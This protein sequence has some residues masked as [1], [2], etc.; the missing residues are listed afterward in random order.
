M[1][2]SSAVP[3]R[4][5]RP[6]LT[7][8]SLSAARPRKASRTTARDTPVRAANSAS[9]GSCDPAERPWPRICRLTSD[10]TRSTRLPDNELASSPSDMFRSSLA[11]TVVTY[12]IAI[13]IN[14]KKK[15]S[16]YL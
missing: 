2:N 13:T 15:T 12:L 8:M 4:A 14:L 3:T 11:S 5:R 1:T 6:L 9:L 16:T 10:M 7:S